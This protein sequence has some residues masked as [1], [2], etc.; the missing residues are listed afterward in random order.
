[1]TFYDLIYV[2]YIPL[3]SFHCPNQPNIQLTQ[4]SSGRFLSFKFVS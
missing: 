3:D 4:N 1:M 2:K